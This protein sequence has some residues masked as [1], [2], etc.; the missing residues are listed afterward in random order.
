MLIGQTWFL[1]PPSGGGRCI[2]L[3]CTTETE[4]GEWGVSPKKSRAG[5]QRKSSVDV[6]QTKTTISPAVIPF[7]FSGAGDSGKISG[8]AVSPFH[9][10]NCLQ[11]LGLMSFTASAH[12]CLLPCGH[13]TPVF[14]P[15]VAVNGLLRATISGIS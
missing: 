12:L 1:A 15:E 3:L 9:F 13:D 14:P 5:V 6:G 4:S 7:D 10:Q 8:L 11:V 2:Y